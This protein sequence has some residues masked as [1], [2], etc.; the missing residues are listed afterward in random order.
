MTN[1][2]AKLRDLSNQAF[3]LSDL[4]KKLLLGNLSGGLMGMVNDESI[5][6][7][8]REEIVECFERAYNFAKS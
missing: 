1:E 6:V 5:P 8:I 7:K 4:D 2:R 3:T